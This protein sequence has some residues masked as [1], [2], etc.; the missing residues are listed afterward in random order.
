VLCGRF[1]RTAGGRLR[2]GCLGP[3]L[4]AADE[5]LQAG[6]ILG[7]R[8]AE[9]AAE[10]HRPPVDQVRDQAI[11]RTGVTVAVGMAAVLGADGG[12]VV[13]VESLRAA[14]QQVAIFQPQGARGAVRDDG[15]VGVEQQHHQ[16]ADEDQRVEERERHG[17]G[18]EEAQLDGAPQGEDRACD[19]HHEEI[20]AFDDQLLA[21]SLLLHFHAASKKVWDLER[22]HSPPGQGS[23][24]VADWSR[25]GFS[26]H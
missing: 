1:V 15:Q 17:L 3:A 23:A 4:R 12:D 24:Q 20:K 5:A 14:E 22:P 7:V 9:G 2:L 26:A 13:E 25:R 21:G 19:P 11:A 6:G 10:R 16:S 18:W 8:A